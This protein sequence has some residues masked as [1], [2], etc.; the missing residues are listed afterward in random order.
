M[1]NELIKNL[2]EYFDNYEE[3]VKIFDS[4]N[5]E[6]K[7]YPCYNSFYAIKNIIKKLSENNELYLDMKHS[8]TEFTTNFSMK[9]EPTMAIY[10][11]DNSKIC[12]KGDGIY[13]YIMYPNK[14]LREINISIELGYRDRFKNMDNTYIECINNIKKLIPKEYIKK[15]NTGNLRNIISQNINIK[16][17]NDFEKIILE[18]FKIYKIIIKRINEIDGKNY[19]ERYNKF[20]ELISKGE[21]KVVDIYEKDISYNTIY[22][23]IPGSGKSYYIKNKLLEELQIKEYERVTFYPEYTYSDFIGTYKIT[24]DKENPIKPEAGPFTRMLIKA[25]K[26][27]DNNNYALVIEELNRGNAEAIFGDIFQ[28]LDRE[29]GESEYHINNDFIKECMQKEKIK[30]EEIKI[31]KNLYIIAT[32]NTSDQN[33]FSLDTAFGRR[34]NYERIDDAFSIEH[35]E[36]KYSEKYIKGFANIKWNDFRTSINETI[37]KPENNIWNREDKQLGLFYISKDQLYTKEQ[38]QDKEGYEK[39]RK[40]FVYKIIRYLWFDVFKN[41]EEKLINAL[42]NTNLIE[43]EIKICYSFDELAKQIIELDEIE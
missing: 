31:P 14:E 1:N 18:M 39:K 12:Y 23:G 41:E 20:I 3:S 5:K 30:R 22:Y 27:E 17:I 26:D 37:L 28:L 16:M 24:S 7:R 38:K 25:L 15:F 21:C 43:K 19:E 34:W 13:V 35:D 4:G 10:Y 9:L 2:K 42:N 8:N 32:I 36:E 6:R 29:N 11:N 40:E 33:V